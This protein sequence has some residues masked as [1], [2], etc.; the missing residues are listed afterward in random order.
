MAERASKIHLAVD[1]Y[2]NPLTFILSDGTTHDVHVALDLIHK[3][4]LSDT[5][6]VYV[7]KGYDFETLRVHV[8]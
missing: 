1:I 8:K 7:N 2:D 3:I 6:I 5:A 4:A